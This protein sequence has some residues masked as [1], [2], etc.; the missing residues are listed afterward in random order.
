M[1][2]FKWHLN[3]LRRTGHNGNQN[4]IG[5]WQVAQVARPLAPW[6]ADPIMQHTCHKQGLM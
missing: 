6:I 1:Y 2:S 4:E 5:S 3:F